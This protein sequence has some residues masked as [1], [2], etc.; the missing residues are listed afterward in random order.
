MKEQAQGQRTIGRY[1]GRK[2]IIAGVIVAIGLLIMVTVMKIS[3]CQVLAGEAMA[4]RAEY[5]LEYTQ[6][7]RDRIGYYFTEEYLTSE[8][9]SQAR[10]RY[11][12]YNLTRYTINPSV[13]WIWVWPWSNTATVRVYDKVTNLAGQRLDLGADDTDTSIPQ[14][15]LGE[16]TLKMRRID[17]KWLIES[18]EVYRLDEEPSAS[19]SPSTSPE[20]SPAES[21]QAEDAS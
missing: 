14:W 13:T 3:A 2:A 5:I 10:A 18:V 8:E 6:D 19:P 16:Y 17:G 11:E 21:P 15:P 7:S 4:V 20:Q 12:N 9:L 1:F